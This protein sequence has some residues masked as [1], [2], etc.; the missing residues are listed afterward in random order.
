MG[1][2]VPQTMTVTHPSTLALGATSIMVNAPA[3]SMIGLTVRENERNIK[4]VG[5]GP[6]TGGPE[7]ITITDPQTEA[8]ILTVTVTKPN[9]YRYEGHVYTPELGT[10]TQYGNGLA[11]SGGYVPDLSGAG[12]PIY[13]GDFSVELTQVL[14]GTT[15]LLYLGQ[16]QANYPLMGGTLYVYPI[17]FTIP[18]VLGGSGPGNGNLSIQATAFFGGVNVYMQAL[19]V[20]AGAVKGVSMTNGLE[21]V[22]P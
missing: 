14:G 12:E 21:I 22:F 17:D 19:C 11:G 13:G 1:S 15:G 8:R 2:K 10:F 9:H 16:T 7:A 4:L 5:S 18:I 6:G 20:D 3:G